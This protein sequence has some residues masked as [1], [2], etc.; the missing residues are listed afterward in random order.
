MTDTRMFLIFE[1][2]NQIVLQ[3]KF[4]PGQLELQFSKDRAWALLDWLR[5]DEPDK[6]EFVETIEG[7]TLKLSDSVD[8]IQFTIVL[9]GGHSGTLSKSQQQYTLLVS[10]LEKVLNPQPP[11]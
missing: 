1:R 3:D 5:D 7:V 8:H 2:D 6:E 11:A 9:K 4:G 10:D